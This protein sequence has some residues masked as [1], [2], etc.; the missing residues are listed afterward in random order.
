MKQGAHTYHGHKIGR[1]DRL[2][3]KLGPL[4]KIRP[5]VWLSVFPGDQALTTAKNQKPAPK[6][7]RHAKA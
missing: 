2:L 1:A 6:L 5:E 7:T 3:S 4:A